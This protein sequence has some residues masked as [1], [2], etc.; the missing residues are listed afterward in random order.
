MGDVWFP[1][2]QIPWVA[3]AVQ[4]AVAVPPTATP[5]GV[6]TL[7]PSDAEKLS[8]SVLAI[9]QHQVHESTAYNAL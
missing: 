9:S 5:D 8:P 4:L 6:G 2:R 3:S 1:E 7:A